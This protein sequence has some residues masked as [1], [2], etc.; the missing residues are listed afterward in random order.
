MAV[1]NYRRV[2]LTKPFQEQETTHSTHHP[3]VK[4]QLE[5]QIV[6]WPRHTVSL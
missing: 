1:D 5:V 2:V 6:E 4:W 3:K